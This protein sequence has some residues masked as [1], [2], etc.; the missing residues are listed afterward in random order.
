M[1]GLMGGRGMNT[2]T[3]RHNGRLARLG[4]W[5]RLW[6]IVC[7]IW[8]IGAGLV[9]TS[10][11]PTSRTVDVGYE[12][13]VED[14]IG[15]KAWRARRA[16]AV[17]HV[18]LLTSRAALERR[19][20][21]QAR[22]ELRDDLPKLLEELIRSADAAGD[23]DTVRKLGRQFLALREN[24]DERGPAKVVA[25]TIAVTPLERFGRWLMETA[26]AVLSIPLLLLGVGLMVRWIYRGF[27]PPRP[28]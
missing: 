19:I 18:P 17:E 3:G 4:G 26:A 11:F 23:G 24:P 20:R 14:P 5:W 27:R 22:A 15:G 28:A 21:R 10:G 7:A 6:I 9:S 8:A 1:S 25:V 12:F 16:F 2:V 13:R